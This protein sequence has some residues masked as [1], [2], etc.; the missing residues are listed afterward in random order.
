MNQSAPLAKPTAKVVT[1]ILST[2]NGEAFLAQQL[3]SLFSQSYPGI[4]ILARDDVST[5]LTP[6]ILA[7][8]ELSARVECLRDGGH[9]GAAQSYFTLLKTAAATSTDYIAFCDQ[10]D[11][12][13][14]DKI[15]R[16]VAALSTLPDGKPALYCSRLEIV[17]EKLSPLGITVTPNRIGFGNALVENVC[18]GCTIVLNR[19]AVDLLCQNLPADA[20]VHDWWCYLVISCFGEIIFD[21]DA[22]IRYRQHGKNVFGVALGRFDRFKRNLRRFAGK[23]AGRHWQSEQAAEFLAAFG[24]RIPDRER[25]MLNDFV[26]AKSSLRARLKL[27]LSNQIWRQTRL[28]DFLWRVLILMNRF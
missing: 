20:I 12:W 9:L 17:D 13:R 8:A 5:D 27:S 22:T 26:K 18:V 1:I 14:A 10:D 19:E 7:E 24:N 6:R 4:R 23:G 21:P 16:A 11:L 28:D 25:R 3:E 2:F 15:S